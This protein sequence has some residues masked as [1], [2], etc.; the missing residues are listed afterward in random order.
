MF[1]SIP[2]V[3]KAEKRKKTNKTKLIKVTV[4]FWLTRTFNRI[5]E[6]SE[7]IG[8]LRLT[9]QRG[10]PTKSAKDSLNKRDI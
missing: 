9:R 10:K 2:V 4:V 5:V 6:G 7:A 8:T 3:D 1:L